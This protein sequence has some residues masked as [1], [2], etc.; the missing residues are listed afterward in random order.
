MTEKS[1]GKLERMP[2]RDVWAHEADDF[3]PWL[4]KEANLELLGDA[5]GMELELEEKEKEVGPFSADILCKNTDDDSWVVIENQIERTDHGHLGQ[6]LTYAA[7]LEAET[8]VWIAAKFRDEHRAALDLLNEITDKNFRFF[9]LEVELWRIDESDPAPKFNVISKPN[10]WTREVRRISKQPSPIREMQLR[11]W[12]QL[13]EYIEAS[14]SD[15]NLQ[16]PAGKHWY[17]FT[18]GH[19]GFRIEASRNSREQQIRVQLDI[20]DREH[21][22][23]FFNMLAED[24]EAIEREIGAELEWREMEGK[25]SSKIAQAKKADPKN[26][27][28]WPNQ[29]AWLKD[30]VEA[31]D[32]AFRDRIAKLDPEDWNPEA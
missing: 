19:S 9:G 29:H 24:K 20:K 26:E 14:G 6:L 25:V 8:I 28:D 2:L 11:Y 31:F 3:T 32:R 30:R 27:A 17:Y 1:L 16:T 21:A 23:A 18:I 7:G 10:D 22:K 13:R 15:L 5:I 4:S 12:E